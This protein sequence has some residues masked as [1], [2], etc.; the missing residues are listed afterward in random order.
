MNYI[1]IAAAV[2]QA[3]NLNCSGENVAY[4]DYKQTAAS[5][6]TIIR[7]DMRRGVWCEG[8]CRE[9]ANISDVQPVKITL[10]S[11]DQRNG[12]SRRQSNIWV[13]RETGEF[14]SVKSW[15]SRYESLRTEIR[16][17]RCEKSAFTAFPSFETKF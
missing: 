8:E 7:V 2:A 16:R 11:I 4:A 3:F 10:E 17:G 1:L 15:Q 13:D 14:R 5:F 9:I 6:T 12:E